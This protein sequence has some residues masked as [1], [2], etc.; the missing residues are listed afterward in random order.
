M[1]ATARLN[2]AG[3]AP[4]AGAAPGIVLDGGANNGSVANIYLDCGTF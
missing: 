3:A 2:F 4:V 1:G